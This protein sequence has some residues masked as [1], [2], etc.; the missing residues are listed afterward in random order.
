MAGVVARGDRPTSVPGVS[1]TSILRDGR[2]SLGDAD[3]SLARRRTREK[4]RL[5]SPR[6]ARTHARTQA[7]TRDVRT[8]L[9][10]LE[11]REEEFG[12]RW[13]RPY[14]TLLPSQTRF[15]PSAGRVE[16]FLLTRARCHSTCLPS[17]CRERRARKKD[18]ERERERERQPARRRCVHRRVSRT[19]DDQPG[20]RTGSASS[21][22]FRRVAD[23]RHGRASRVNRRGGET[24]RKRAEGRNTTHCIR[25]MRSLAF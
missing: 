11:S 19:D 16:T 12:A 4:R 23:T 20:R 13:P 8:L 21:R 24:R 22:I 6:V 1:Y 15:S 17:L 25:N 7:S 5:A 3:G 9:D 10:D 14:R 18:T 2:K